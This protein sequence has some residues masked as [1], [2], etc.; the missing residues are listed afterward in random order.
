MVRIHAI[1][2][3][4]LFTLSA[5]ACAPKSAAAP[6]AP[7]AA[8]RDTHEL[9]QGVLWVQTSGEFGA[10]TSAAYRGARRTLDDA[11]ADGKWTAAL[12]QT[13]GFEALPP[14]VIL[15]LDE[16]VLDNSPA[17]GQLVIDRTVYSAP[18][19]R[20]WV[21]S[22]QATLIPGAKEF[23]DFAA[24]RGVRIFF[25]TNRR[26]AD[27][28]DEDE[29]APTIENL[30]RLGVDASPDTVLCPGENGWTSDKT[31]RRTELA[32]RFRILLLVGDDMNDFVSTAGMSAAA[33]RALA[34]THGPRWGERWVLL[35]NPLYGSW[36]SSLLGLPANTP[37]AQVLD[38]KR[39]S[40]HGFERK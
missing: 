34:A 15:D 27:S 25:V 39:S 37:D 19:W 30:R 24:R 22:Q 33:R 23:L 38:R 36:E 14:A 17:Q 18:F 10:L 1:A 40:V 16:T 31:A 29:E 5:A 6:R 8:G 12:E 32:Q 7:A 2:A 3:V 20:S 13:A 26:H 9:L 35:P 21:R 11:L 4:T 28:P